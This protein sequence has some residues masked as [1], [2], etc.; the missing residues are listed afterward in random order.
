MFATI[1]RYQGQ[2]GTLDDVAQQVQAELV[3]LLSTQPGFVS[4]NA[5][6]AGNDVAISMTIFR[7]R[8]A[9]EAANK[10]AADWV[11]KNIGTQVGAPEV[12]FGEVV[13]STNRE[14]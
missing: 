11:K 9:A 14:L 10:L 12:T 2:K 5:I 4:Y 1:R 7:D 8:A 6:N 3:P 13:A